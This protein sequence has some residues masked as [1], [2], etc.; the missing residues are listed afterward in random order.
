M[1]GFGGLDQKARVLAYDF[2]KDRAGMDEKEATKNVE[3]GFGNYNKANWTE[4]MRRWARALLFP[5]WDF[6]SLKWFLR[7]P[8]KTAFLPAL[9]TIGANL[10]LNKAGKNRDSDK[11]DFAYLHYGDRS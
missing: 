3:D 9:A 2:L 8:I 7:H 11:Y 4:R 6:S 1:G 5:G 10:A